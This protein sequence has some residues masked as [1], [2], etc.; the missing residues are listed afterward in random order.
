MHR[1]S[2]P[3]PIVSV[4]GR[5]ARICIVSPFTLG[6]HFNSVISPVL[7]GLA[8][9]LIASGNH[10][11][12]LAITHY[13]D[14]VFDEERASIAERGIELQV[15][16]L[17]DTT[18]HTA[19]RVYQQ[20]RTGNY[21]I[22]HAPD[23]G[24]TLYAALTARDMGLAFT[25]VRFVV[26]A[27]GGT[28][29]QHEMRCEFIPSPTLL[30]D[31]FIERQAMLMADQVVVP[32]RYMG[33]YLTAEEWV[34]KEPVILRPAMPS[35]LERELPRVALPT[36]FDMP[37]PIVE[38]VFCTTIGAEAG[39]EAFLAALTL[40]SNRKVKL[41]KII[42]IGQPSKTAVVG[43]AIHLANWAATYRGEWDLIPRADLGWITRYLCQPGR[44]AVIA[45][46]M[47]STSQLLAFCLDARIPFLA[48]NAEGFTD[49]VVP[50][51]HDLCFCNPDP[52]FFSKRIEQMCR[53]GISRL[54]RPQVSAAQRFADLQEWHL[55]LVNVPLS[56]EKPG[57]LTASTPMV[58]V[59]LTHFNR[60]DLLHQ[61]ILSLKEQI[62]E[63][64]E[65]ILVDDASPGEE[66]KAFLDRLE[67]HF[68]SLGWTVIRNEQ[69]IWPAACR[70]KA[71][72]LANGEY[73]LF[74]DDDNVAL[75][76]EISTFVRAARASGSDFLTCLSIPFSG[77]ADPR[78]RVPI[79]EPKYFPIGADLSSA[80]IGNCFGD[81]NMLAR[82]AAFMRLGGFD[83]RPL[84]AED[85]HLAAKAVAAGMK[86]Q[87]VPEPLYYYRSSERSMGNTLD[88]ER[89]YESIQR[90][91]EPILD[92]ARAD[93]QDSFRLMHE[94]THAQIQRSGSSYW[95]CQG[96]ANDSS[97]H[98]LR[99]TD[100]ASPAYLEAAFD[101]AVEQE[102]H[103]MV[104]S[105]GD[106]LLCRPA[107]DLSV[108]ATYLTS[109][110]IL[111]G[112]DAGVA[113]V[114]RVAALI[115]LN[116]S[117]GDLEQFAAPLAFCRER[118]YDKTGAAIGRMLVK[119]T[120]LSQSLWV[121]CVQALSRTCEEQA[122]VD[123]IARVGHGTAFVDLAATA[124][125]EMLPVATDNTILHLIERL[126]GGD[127]DRIT[128]LCNVAAIA[129]LQNGLPR[130]RE[131]YM[132]R[133][134]ELDGGNT[135][136]LAALMSW[137]AS[138]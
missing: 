16:H 7:D 51:D 56:G 19:Y 79:G 29:W 94:Q 25:G 100:S 6:Q 30:S 138:S 24:G 11:T 87:V 20:L 67:P 60:P 102:A 134:R 125:T 132:S 98:R 61:A 22:V 58:T 35:A 76:H 135:Q 81:A 50:D 112:D 106:T 47:A 48:A 103:D 109:S 122:I 72:A 136:K 123:L 111:G 88:V 17:G 120:S 118:N 126:A 95:R 85:H 38:I 92:L 116:G 10:V 86:F 104:V 68:H 34:K 33:N 55:A 1:A 15:L 70:N 80:I 31:D 97:G 133:L 43:P 114:D 93:L 21:D 129:L 52:K 41:P 130:R 99:G 46:R 137:Y 75:P 53:D 101:F 105:L 62:Y 28:F 26:H 124:V 44:L 115:P 117:L 36:Q 110:A 2:F 84:G 113:A 8:D 71:A 82:R 121:P 83:E 49:L 90:T 59:C 37:Q 107:F 32:S 127:R 66:T 73:L 91:L 54:P 74:M 27:F 108:A 45:P 96:L 40:L 69:E 57:H 18:G 119:Q 64:I 9:A 14:R 78:G 65:V 23:L 89:I 12:L 128:R 63:N 42:F 3:E 4:A 13:T 39:L 77:D 131:I 5:K